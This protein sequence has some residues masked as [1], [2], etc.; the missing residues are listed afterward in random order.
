MKKKAKEPPVPSE[1][2]ET[3]RQ[4]IISALTGRLLSSKDISAEVGIP[5]KS[6]YEHLDHIQR[7]LHGKDRRLSVTP[8]ECLTCGFVFRKRER[9]SKPGRCPVCRSELIREPLFSL[10]V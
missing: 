4:E 7:S 1:R 8:A 3:V 10:P 5:E 6:V 9:L 2:R